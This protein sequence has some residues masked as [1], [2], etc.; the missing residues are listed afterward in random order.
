[1]RL[2]RRPAAHADRVDARVISHAVSFD[3]APDPDARGRLLRAVAEAVVLQD[4]AIAVLADIR[5]REPLDVVAQRAGPLARRFLAL[6]QEL[7]PAEDAVLARQ[8]ATASVVLDHHGR[9]L[10][11]GL[12]LLAAEW[13]SERIADQ[14]ERLDGLGAPAE[15]LDALYA[16][17]TH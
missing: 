10:V 12:E 13:R 16:E 11:H 8:C 15:R 14:L 9:V 1:M 17:L 7:P 5:N 2:F 4:E 3:D 6:R